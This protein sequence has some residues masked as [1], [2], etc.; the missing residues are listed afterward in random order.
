[1]ARK[2]VYKVIFQNQGRIF[3]VYARGVHQG[4]MFGFIEVEKL[5]FGE[6]TTLV[7]DPS[8]ENLKT[9]FKGV[10]RTYIPLHS[11]V[12]IDEVEREGAAKITE[13]PAKDSKITPFPIYTR[14]QEDST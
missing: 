9:E 14:G 13:V 4:G 7:V 8:E 12:R 6:K 3:E 5:I 1:M 2:P 10:V 11:I